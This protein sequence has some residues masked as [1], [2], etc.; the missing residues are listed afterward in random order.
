MSRLPSPSNDT[1]SSKSEAAR[2]FLRKWNPP[3]HPQEQQEQ[4]RY[5]IPPRRSQLC[6]SIL[7]SVHADDASEYDYEHDYEYRTCTVKSS[8]K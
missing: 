1:D 2:L 5:G 8:S 7:H 4:Q 3:N 6:C